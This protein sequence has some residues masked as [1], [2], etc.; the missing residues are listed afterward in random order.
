MLVPTVIMGVIAVLLLFIGFYKG[1]GQ[2]ISGMRSALGMIIEVLP[3]LIF[4]L[5]IAGMAQTLL[6]QEMVAKWVG[7]EFSGRRVLPGGPFCQSP[8]RS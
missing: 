8:H 1:Q 2:H 4:A 3:L 6:S 5:I 7:T